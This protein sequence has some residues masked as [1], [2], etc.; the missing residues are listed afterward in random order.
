MSVARDVAEGMGEGLGDAWYELE[1][2]E[3]AISYVGSRIHRRRGRCGPG[4]WSH[5][6]AATLSRALRRAPSA[7]ATLTPIPAATRDQVGSGAGL[8]LSPYR[9]GFTG[10]WLQQTGPGAQH[11]P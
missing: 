7:E 5:L 10:Q 6:S 4:G 1:N 2:G 3:Y 11:V 9:F 8:D